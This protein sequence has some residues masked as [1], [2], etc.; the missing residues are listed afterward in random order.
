MKNMTSS[1]MVATTAAGTL[2]VVG[3]IYTLA[4]NGEV[5]EPAS[6]EA[7]EAVSYNVV[8]AALPL[9]ASDVV[10]VAAGEAIA[11]VVG[12]ATSFGISLSMRMSTWRKTGESGS[13][14]SNAEGMVKVSDAVADG[15][16]L[17]TNAAAYPLLASI[18]LSPLVSAVTS[19]LLAIVPYSI[20]KVGA[21]RREALKR[22]DILLQELLEQ[23]HQRKRRR[24][25]GFGL[26]VNMSASSSRR[27][28]TVPVGVTIVDPTTLT[29]VQEDKPK[30]DA[31]E[32]FSDI[33][34]WLQFSVL[35]KEFSGRLLYEGQELL[36]G[37]ESA[38]LG[39]V[40]GVS[41]QFYS[42][43]LYAFFKFGGEAKQEMVRSRSVLDW[44]N[45]YTAKTIYFA[46]LFGVYEAVQA[47]A[48][49]FIA[50][51]LSG[52]AEACYGSEDFRA[53]IETYVILN[54]PGASPEAQLRSFI[55]AAVSFWNNYSVPTWFSAQ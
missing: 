49:D 21:R 48:K 36:P 52:G 29:P 11:G 40:A 47:P 23:E 22:E 5:T 43:I 16:F 37:V 28:D 32:T 38:I 17:L 7:L 39:S 18:G 8:D 42:D 50:A 45:I 41:S 30:L 19:T 9:T 53:C 31:V 15:D 54:P 34:K 6:L 44:L 12:A 2:L 14:N 26:P 35:T 20:V 4:L 27:A 1:E 55:T 24:Q 10:S 25:V 33:L 13:K 51:F 46:V 3:L